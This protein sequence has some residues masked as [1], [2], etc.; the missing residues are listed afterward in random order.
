MPVLPLPLSFTV[1]VA[2]PLAMA[3]ALPT[4]LPIVV[5]VPVP[6]AG[7]VAAAL[8][9]GAAVVAFSGPL[10]PKREGTS[11]SFFFLM[12]LIF[13]VASQQSHGDKE[14]KWYLEAEP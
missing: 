4:A 7:L 12:Q 3:V 2:I 8:L 6:A 5:L 11:V 10:P 9:S 1:A 13:E 14:F